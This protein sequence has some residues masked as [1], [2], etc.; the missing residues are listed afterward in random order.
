MDRQCG[1]GNR[2]SPLVSARDHRVEA[3]GP[4]SLDGS[5]ARAFHG[6]PERWNPEQLFLAALSQCHMLS[7]FYVA[8]R[9]GVVVTAYR[10]DARGTLSNG[11]AAGARSP[12]SC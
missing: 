8:A 10:D 2:G 9:A 12:R 1:L 5:A 4:G 11:R 6:D 7:Y 3:P